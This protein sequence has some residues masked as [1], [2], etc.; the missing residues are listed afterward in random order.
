MA[1]SLQF[2][3]QKIAHAR[4]EQELRLHFMDAVGEYFGVQRWGI[5]LLN[6]QSH[7]ASVDI[8]GMPDA[9]SFVECYSNIGR[10][11]DPVLKYVVE[12]HAPAHEELVLPA[13]GW[14]QSDLYLR[15]CRYYNHEH[16]MTGP[17]VGGGSLVGT[18]NFARIGDTPAFSH[19]D[20]VDL[21]ALCLHISACLA[22]VRTNSERFV[23]LDTRL[24]KRERQIAELVSQGLTNAEI[25]AELWITKNSVKQALKRMFRKLDVVN[26][27]QMVAH[28]QN[29][30]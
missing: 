1:Q 7:L 8:C 30:F 19:Q 12:R 18:V 10:E 22:R 29:Y 4:N 5:S 21:S 6:Q 25:S 3:F 2:L 26:R 17:I 16:I 13:G 14:K 27:A 11:V 20:L 9:D 15:C 23:L 28:L 24:T